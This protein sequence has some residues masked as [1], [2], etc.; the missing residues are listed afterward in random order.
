MNDRRICKWNKIMIKN[1]D[2]CYKCPDFMIMPAS[3][4]DDIPNL[5]KLYIMIIIKRGIY[6]GQTHVLEFNAKYGSS[7]EYY[8]PYSPPFVRFITKIFHPNISVTGIICVDILKEIDKWSAQYSIVNVMTSIMLL[9]DF[10]NNSSPYNI[11]SSDMYIQC[12]KK[13]KSE[14]NG[15]KLSLIEEERIEEECFNEYSKITKKYANTNISNYIT[16][17]NEHELIICEN[18]ITK[19]KIK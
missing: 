11:E 5:E 3:Y 15:K 1:L 10:P 2:E 8:F 18:K 4:N 16:M 17:F 12:N 9:L 13:I 6:K 14:K 19:L 7:T